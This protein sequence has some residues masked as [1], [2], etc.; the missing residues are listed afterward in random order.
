MY[1][2]KRLALV[3]TPAEKVAVVQMAEDEGGLSQSTL[4]RRLIRNTAREQGIWLPKQRRHTIMR[5]EESQHGR[6]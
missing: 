5:I 1:E 4:V 6:V 2:T 3:L